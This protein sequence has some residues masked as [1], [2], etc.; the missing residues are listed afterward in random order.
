MVGALFSGTSVRCGTVTTLLFELF[1]F[2][3]KQIFIALKQQGIV[4][5]KHSEALDTHKQEI[6]VGVLLLRELQNILDWKRKG[7]SVVQLG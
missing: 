7:G 3:D 6:V 4:R 5:D 2:L 1:P